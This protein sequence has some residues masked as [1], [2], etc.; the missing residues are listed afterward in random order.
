[1]ASKRMKLIAYVIPTVGILL[2]LCIYAIH[3]LEPPQT[4]S[5]VPVLSDEDRKP[6]GLPLNGQLTLATKADVKNGRTVSEDIKKA[7]SALVPKKTKW[8]ICAARDTGAHVL[9]W[10]GYPEIMDGGDFL[11][12]S[13]KGKR[14]I[15]SFHGGELG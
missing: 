1:M 10:I 5:N 11:I 14:I 4:I 9:L 2:V 15:G 7:V 8:G 6:L 12:Y 13:K 3:R